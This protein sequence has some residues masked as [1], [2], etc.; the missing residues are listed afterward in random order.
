MMTRGQSLRGRDREQT[1]TEEQVVSAAAQDKR[2][3]ESSSFPWR[4]LGGGVEGRPL[5]RRGASLHTLFHTLWRLNRHM[6]FLNQTPQQSRA[7]QLQQA[8]TILLVSN[9]ICLP[10]SAQGGA[11]HMSY[12]LKRLLVHE[13]TYVF[14]CVLHPQFLYTPVWGPG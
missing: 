3:Q 2:S 4:P 14:W 9:P 1:G 7:E 11:V 8:Y 6:H 5:G 13:H 10:S 12:H